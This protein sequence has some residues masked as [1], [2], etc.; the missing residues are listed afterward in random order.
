MTAQSFGSHVASN[1]ATNVNTPGYSRRI[2]NIQPVGGPPEPGNGARAVGQRR[3]VDQFLERR[4]LGA[5]SF[6]GEASARSG[7]LGVLDVIFSDG[8]GNLGDAIDAFHSA[9][10]D[11]AA[12]PS[13]PGPRVTLLSRAEQVADA[14]HVAAGE[15]VQSRVDLNERIQGEV[16]E[17]NDR[18][19]EIGSLGVQ[20]AQSE[21]GGREASDLR[22]RRD[23]LVRD[24]A[25]QVPVKV[26]DEG[27]GTISLLLSGGLPLVS[28]D[29]H[30]EGLQTSIDPTS[31]D[32]QIYRTTAGAV[33]D[34]TATIGSGIIG[35]LID[36]RDGALSDARDSLDQLAFDFAAA[37]N[38]AH[39]AGVG[40]DGA[41][42]RNIF[43]PLASAA[44]A[45]E[46]IGIS[47]DVAGLPDAIGA[48]ADATATPGDNRNALALLDLSE[49]PIALGGTATVTDA[50]ASLIATGA[51]AVQVAIGQ[52]EAAGA[53]LEQVT[54]LREGVSG[55]SVDEE[56]VSLTQFQRAY[57]ASLR[58]IQT[59][60]EMLGE[61]MNLR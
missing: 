11:L 10:A 39:A 56:M 48:A 27:D 61:L 1:N 38:T 57:Q 51:S 53:A 18:L 21:L 22:D 30:V 55:V 26:L 17:L 13:D 46:S 19:D 35:G 5:Q 33:V 47:A 20:I 2:A 42:G 36:A 32:T 6:Q 14:F 49:A 40:L 34:I 25:E 24:V 54:A 16:A 3:V 41:S 7:A 4:M 50:Y 43:E 44:G 58:V 8:A 31:G 15:L 28:P 37:Y 59:A 23:Q 52:E 12:Y 9:I 29:G 60:D 45:A